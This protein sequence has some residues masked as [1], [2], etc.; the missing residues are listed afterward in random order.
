MLKDD[1]L[2]VFNFQQ[3]CCLHITVTTDVKLRKK[4]SAVAWQTVHENI[5]ADAFRSKKSPL[6]LF[7]HEQE[8]PQK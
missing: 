8:A 3:R 1:T 7:V 5:V 2:N 4:I 6:A